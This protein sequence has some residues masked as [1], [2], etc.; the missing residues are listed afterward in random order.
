MKHVARIKYGVFIQESE[1]VVAFNFNVVMK[2][3]DFS[4]SH[5]VT[6]TE[7]VVI[8]R[9]WYETETMLQTDH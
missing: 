1:N 9:K 5:A 3:K 4:R 2:L 8:F 6:Y 7:K